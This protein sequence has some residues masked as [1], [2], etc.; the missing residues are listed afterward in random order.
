MGRQEILELPSE[1]ETAAQEANGQSDLIDRIEKEKTMG[2][3]SSRT[4]ALLIYRMEAFNEAHPCGLIFG[5]DCGYKIF[6]HAPKQVRYPD[7]SFVGLR[8][9]PDDQPPEGH[10]EIA[11]D[12]AVEVVSPND[13]AEEIE[14]RVVDYLRAGVPL[15]WVLYPNTRSIH[16]IRRGVPGRH[17]LEGDELQGE[18]VVPGFTCRVEQLFPRKVP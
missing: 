4:G 18:E 13:P 15:V 17:L 14:E 5:S 6:P 12:L 16:V 1:L 9:L 2:A 11:P 3:K 10:I 7:V 8:R